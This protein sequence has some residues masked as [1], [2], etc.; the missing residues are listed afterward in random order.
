MNDKQKLMK[1]FS[2]LKYPDLFAIRPC[3]RDQ[4]CSILPKVS[5]F[6]KSDLSKIGELSPAFS[7]ITL[8]AGERLIE[9]GKICDLAF[10]L[11]SGKLAVEGADHLTLAPYDIVGE[12]ALFLKQPRNATVTTLE[13]CDLLSFDEALFELLLENDPHSLRLLKELI[14]SR[15]KNSHFRRYVSKVFG[16]L[17]GELIAALEREVREVGLKRGET[18]FCQGDA[19]DGIYLLLSGRLEIYQ[20][21]KLIG[22]ISSGEVLGEIGVITEKPRSATAVASRYSTLLMVPQTLFYRLQG[23][24]PLIA[25]NLLKLSLERIEEQKKAIHRKAPPNVVALLPLSP[26]PAKAIGEELSLALVEM[27]KTCKMIDRSEA[28]SK[29]SIDFTSPLRSGSPHLTH[30]LYWINDLA[31]ES[32]FLFLIADHSGSPWTEIALDHSDEVL[33]IADAARS[34]ELTEVEAASLAGRGAKMRLLLLQK[35]NI[36]R[37]TGSAAWREKREL[38]SHH[39]LKGLNKREIAAVARFIANRPTVLL[40]GG[41]GAKAFAHLGLLSVLEREKI[42]IDSI[43]GCNVGALIAAIFAYAGS[44]SDALTLLHNFVENIRLGYS[45]PIISLMS[46]KELEKGL[47]DIFGSTD[48]E[49]LW[50]PLYSF[51]A[52]LSTAELLLQDSGSLV[53]AL[54][55][56]M[57]TSGLFPPLVKNGNLL[58]DPSI[59]DHLPIEAVREKLRGGVVYASDVVPPVEMEG[60][61]AKRYG[62]T[63]FELLTKDLQDSE[64]YRLPNIASLLLRAGHLGS[65]YNNKKRNKGA[66][67]YFF[68]TLSS[69]S[70]TDFAKYREIEKEGEKCAEDSLKGLSSRER[71]QLVYCR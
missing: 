6:S 22:E 38:I 13:R 51:S 69:Y 24:S 33:L 29:L 60:C 27:G 52:N 68:H 30:F 64:E 41:G 8:A 23:E 18:L 28:A 20:G 16:E 3:E 70:F 17:N 44:Y 54:L 62:I 46:G 12:T 63:L 61:R 2:H 1:K 11:L 14:D 4:L 21:E 39:H 53:E 65:L 26:L 10:I 67:I 40:L 5:L 34:P 58:V 31:E 7:I 47:Y 9:K 43:A 57:S 56:S 35:E 25:H 55:A 45:L 36:A 37:P 48:I 59:I 71:M 15:L 66:D 19:S 50:L 42:A 49:D 32:N